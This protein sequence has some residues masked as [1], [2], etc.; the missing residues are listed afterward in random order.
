MVQASNSCIQMVV[1]IP[2]HLITELVK[3]RNSNV[4]VIQM[5]AIQ[6]PLYL[7]SDLKVQIFNGR[8]SDP[9][10]ATILILDSSQFGIWMSG[11]SISTV[12]WNNSYLGLVQTVDPSHGKNWSWFL[13]MDPAPYF[14]S[15]CQNAATFG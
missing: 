13:Q 6:I 10:C 3:V 7:K 8:I 11:I 15:D 4:S 1:W 14:S 2:N 9:H 5:F 12:D